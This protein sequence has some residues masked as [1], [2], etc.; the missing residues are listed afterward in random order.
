VRESYVERAVGG[1]GVIFDSAEKGTK[2]GQA[3]LIFETF[4]GGTLVTGGIHDSSRINPRSH[5]SR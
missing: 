5:Q 4:T 1:S 2:R 3:A